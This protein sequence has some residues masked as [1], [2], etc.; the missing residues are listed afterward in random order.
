MRR[1]WPTVEVGN[2]RDER[3]KFER[4]ARRSRSEQSLA[5]RRKIVLAGDQGLSNA[6]WRKAVS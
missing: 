1:A 6:G 2:E 4:W 3:V 5:L